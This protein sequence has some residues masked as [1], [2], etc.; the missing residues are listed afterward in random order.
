MN[1]VPI[2][3]TGENKIVA[4]RDGVQTEVG[5]PDCIGIQADAT[6]ASKDS[7]SHIWIDHCEFF[8]GNA[9]NV[10]RYDGLVDIK[11]NVQ[12]I[13]LSYN[14]FHDHYKA[15]LF[16]KGD[17]DNYDR[18]VTMH[19]NVFEN[20]VGS[21]L[22]LQRY[23]H[24]HYVNNYMLN[25][26][27]GYDLRTGSIG[28]IE[29]CYFKDSKA[30]V[31]L[32]GEGTTN[33]RTD[34]KDYSIVYDNCPRII[35]N[36]PNFTYLNQS[37]VD[38]EYTWTP[39][40]ANSNSWVPTQTWSD[41]Q[42]NNIDP[43]M[44]VPEVCEQYS[45]AG[46][47]VLW[48][49]YTSNI[50]AEDMNEVKAAV[51]NSSYNTYNI[52]GTK[53]TGDTSEADEY[54]VKFY[55]QGAQVGTTQSVPSGSYAAA[56]SVPEREG[57]TFGGWSV[58]GGNTHVFVPTY[59]ITS[60][61]NFYAIWTE[62][63]PE[64][65]EL[66]LTDAADYI[67]GTYGAGKVSYS[68][69]TTAGR[70]G[71][72]C[73]PFD[74]NLAEAQGIEKAYVPV[75]IALYNTTTNKLQIFLKNASGVIPAGTPFV[76]LFSGSTVLHSSSE[77]TFTL[78]VSN[79]EAATM[80]VFNTSGSDGALLQNEDITVTWNGTY[81]KTDRVNG[82]KSFNSN[83]DF[84]DHTAPTISAFRAF[85]VMTSSSAAS[86]AID[87]EL[88]YGDAAT[89]VERVVANQAANTDAIY[90]ISGQKVNAASR[91]GLYISRGLKVV[92]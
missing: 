62:K 92:K 85:I 13:T 89:A 78:P 64:I 32:R 53:F 10:D 83:G 56:P 72:F 74:F 63:S 48:D 60:A 4:M 9:T 6:S 36:N 67:A 11:N 30:P 50:P 17:S 69:A 16:G 12:W 91:P 15:C 61:T 8:N 1:S 49:T 35:N 41:Y 31:R 3:K 43:V 45:G 40:G 80:R 33:I 28:Y 57:Y 71:S 54:D 21:R 20:I 25:A 66:E 7:G 52:D 37:K 82:M 14:R 5:D 59:A 26:S 55:S 84:G 46:K 88:L 77:A 18:T 39:G 27:D 34:S 47:I 38:E 2:M 90:N 87:V 79:P 86:Q 76:A 75:N 22:P 70:Y 58:D 42:V 51:Q 29:S 68:R 24:L 65:D 73:L 81:V 44:S 23:G 19:H